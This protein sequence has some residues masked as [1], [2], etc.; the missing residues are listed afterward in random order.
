MSQEERPPLSRERVID[1]AVTLADEEGLE[2]VSMRGLGRRLGVEA[3]SLYNHVAGKDG[4]LDGILEYVLGEID[5]PGPDEPW[6]EAFRRRALSCRNVFARHPWAMGLLEKRHTDSSPRR[7]HYYDSVL[8]CLR[9]A[10]F[11]VATAV[12]AFSLVDSYIFGF[13]LEEQ[14]LA[15]DDPESLEE[16]GTD[17]LEQMGGEY[18][19]LTEATRY[20]MESGYDRD[21]ELRFGL[22]LIVDGLRR[23]LE[24]G[25]TRRT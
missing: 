17:L 4:V 18:P 7:L 11:D 23:M 3:M 9:N 19:H 13:I 12:R 22:D 16:V 15:F 14:S 8:G 5:T 20:A 10:G 25:E 21:V 24:K 6:E 1:A 2:A